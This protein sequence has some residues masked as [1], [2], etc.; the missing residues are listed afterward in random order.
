MKWL[1]STKLELEGVGKMFPRSLGLW[2]F[3]ED[4]KTTKTCKRYLD[5]RKDGGFFRG[6]TGPPA[7]C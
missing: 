3:Y 4:L 5:S 2:A 6:K 7:Q 1:E